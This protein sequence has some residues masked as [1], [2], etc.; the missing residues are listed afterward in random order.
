MTNIAEQLRTISSK[1]QADEIA[2]EEA[3]EKLRQSEKK[4]KI[5]QRMDEILS[6][7]LEQAKEG[8]TWLEV[9]RLDPKQYLK[10]W[11]SGNNNIMPAELYGDDRLLAEILINEGFKIYIGWYSPGNEGGDPPEGSVYNYLGITW[12]ENNSKIKP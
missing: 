9:S 4:A 1:V 7:A 5:S 12:K 8:K 6:L 10:F 11:G 2:R 3:S